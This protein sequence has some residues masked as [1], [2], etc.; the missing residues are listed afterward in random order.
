MF[1]LLSIMSEEMHRGATP[2][3]FLFA[4]ENRKVDTKAEGMLWRKLRNRKLKGFKFRRQHPVNQFIADFYCHEC[5]LIIELD[6]EYH[7]I[8]NQK[9]YDAGRTYE[10]LGIGITVLR[11]TNN[12][13]LKELDSVI[14]R[15]L[16]ALDKN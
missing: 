1:L 13:V 11:F 10:L 6:G 7:N 12:E 14:E 2:K 3:L 5:N 15:I 4:R 9:Q 8:E 16:E